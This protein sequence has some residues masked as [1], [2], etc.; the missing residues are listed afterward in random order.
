MANVEVLSQLRLDDEGL[1]SMLD[2]GRRVETSNFEEIKLS[3]QNAG[4]DTDKFMYSSVKSRVE[5]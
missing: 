1:L 3:L 5:F 4:W 2:K